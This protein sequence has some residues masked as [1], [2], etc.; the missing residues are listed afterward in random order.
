VSNETPHHGIIW[1]YRY[2]HFY[3]TLKLDGNETLHDPF[4]LTPR[5]ALPA[6]IWRTLGKSGCVGQKSLLLT[7]IEP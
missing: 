5:K 7:A 1:R 4:A 3:L 6:A 2:R